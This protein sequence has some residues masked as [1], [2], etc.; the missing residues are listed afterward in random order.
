M[1]HKQPYFSGKSSGDQ[2]LKIA[3]MLG[4]K[5]LHE[6]AE[7]YKIK[8]DPSLKDLLGKHSEKP[9]EGIP[10]AAI[11][12]L[13]QMLVYDHQE[14]ITAREALNHAFFKRQESE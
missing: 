13:E 9:W 6:Y 1:F 4:T 14:R 10:E 7:K 12:L 2:L 3:K 8:I 5:K 11:D